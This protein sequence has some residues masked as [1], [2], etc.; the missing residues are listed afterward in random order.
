VK[1]K[2]EPPTFKLLRVQHAQPATPPDVFGFGQLMAQVSLREVREGD[3]RPARSGSDR[4]DAAGDV[5]QFE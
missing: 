1:R 5:S 3:E 2:I 4:V